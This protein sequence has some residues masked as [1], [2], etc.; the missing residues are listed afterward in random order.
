MAS[1]F[2]PASHPPPGRRTRS[3]GPRRPRCLPRLGPNYQHFKWGGPARGTVGAARRPALGTVGAARRPA[4]VTRAGARSGTATISKVPP[5]RDL[6]AFDARATTYEEGWLGRLHHDIAERTARLAVS[7]CPE[8]RRVL[9]VGCGTG[10]LLRQLAGYYP[11][12]IELA[13]VD[14]APTMVEVARSKASHDRLAFSLATAEHLPYA[15]DS[16]DLV[17]STT[18]FDHWSD[19][20][21]GLRECARVL[22]PGGTLVLV[23][24]FSL[25]LAPT[26]LVGRRGKARTKRRCDRLLHA[27][28]FSSLAWHDAYAVLIG[29]VTAR[30]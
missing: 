24:Q 17:V 1:P 5:E 8:A 4:L 13:G 27:A 26:L 2:Q 15:D 11:K 21:G 19:Q 22:E 30:A 3:P 9:D 18:S 7:T 29:A 20:L 25:W 28:G 6:A 12:A 23:D 10:Y 16:F 14:P